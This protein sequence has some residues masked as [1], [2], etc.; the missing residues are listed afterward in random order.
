LQGTIEKT[1]V[2]KYKCAGTFN[3]ISDDTLEIT[4]LP[5]RTWTQS[6]KEQIEAWVV[7]SDKNPALVKVSGLPWHFRGVGTT[8]AD[9]KRGSQ[10]YREYHM[11]TTVHFIITLTKEGQSTIAKD[12]V[13]KTFRLSSTISTSNMVVFDSEGKIRKY[14]TPEQ[15]LDDFYDLRLSYYQKRKVSLRLGFVSNVACLI[16]ERF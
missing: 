12:G 2:D 14:S 5:I 13:E 16:S 10:E 6:Y 8:C 1:G 9:D 4:E 11:H 7:G 3:M 15:I